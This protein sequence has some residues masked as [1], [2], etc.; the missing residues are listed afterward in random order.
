MGIG[1]G[2]RAARPIE[3]HLTTHLQGYQ[4]FSETKGLGAFFTVR[5]GAKMHSVEVDEDFYMGRDAATIRAK[6]EQWQ[7]A[8]LIKNG[9]RKVRI[10]E[11][12]YQVLEQ[13]T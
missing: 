4:V 6:L 8:E 7:I 11:E 1:A 10:L 3:A 12:S 9:A 13:Y 2:H 5:L